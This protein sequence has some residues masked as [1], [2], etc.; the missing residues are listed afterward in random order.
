L[1]CPA[2]DLVALAA[3]L[4]A[5][6]R[7]RF[8]PSPTGWLHIGHVVNAMYTWGIARAL[9]G[10]VLLRIEDHDRERSRPEYERAIL[11]D[12][13]WLDL[14]PGDGGGTPITR[15]RQSDRE[16]VYAE[17][18]ASLQRRDLVYAC[19]CSRKEI[20]QL[21]GET[22]GEPRYPGTCRDRG[23]PCGPGS[24]LRLRMEA[25]LEH[26]HDGLMGAQVQHPASQSGDLLIRDRVGQWT[27]QFA[28]T[29]DDTDQQIDLVIRGEDLLAST[30]RQVRLA[31]LLGRTTPPVYLHHPLLYAST[32]IKLSKSNHDT[33]IR[34]LRARG[35]SP[36]DVLGLAAARAGLIERPFPV[37]TRELSE[38]MRGRGLTAGG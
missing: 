11:D 7:T 10:T 37:S 36:D 38:L 18:L 33:G 26:F 15:S 21:T 9:G 4:P 23:L 20:G 24:G 22:A 3:R 29:V 6:P 30:G 16:S 31:R 34:E 1:K 25:G 2:P 27:Y 12:L 5:R 32:G 8:A 13:A 17:A 19:A 28:V 35:L 14:Q